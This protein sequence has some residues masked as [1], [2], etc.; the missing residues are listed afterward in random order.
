MASEMLAVSGKVRA[1]FALWL[2]LVALLEGGQFIIFPCNHMPA[3]SL[4][5]GF[6]VFAL[7]AALVLKARH[8]QKLFAFKGNQTRTGR[9]INTLGIVL[10]MILAV[11]SLPV[12]LLTHLCP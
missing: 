3:W 4:L 1:D 8:R 9:T 2:A 10:A 11:I 5:F 6:P 12:W 7:F